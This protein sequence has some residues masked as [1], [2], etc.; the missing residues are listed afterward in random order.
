M[1]ANGGV[2]MRPYLVV[3]PG[4]MDMGMG[5]MAMPAAPKDRTRPAP[6]K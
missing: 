5:Q 6:K 4:L 3:P 1:P 2:V